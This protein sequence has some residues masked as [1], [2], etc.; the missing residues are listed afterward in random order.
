MKCSPV[1]LRLFSKHG[2]ERPCTLVLST[3]GP[4]SPSSAADLIVEGV[5]TS[6]ELDPQGSSGTEILFLNYNR[7]S[8]IDKEMSYLCVHCSVPTDSTQ[9]TSEKHLGAPPKKPNCFLYYTGIDFFVTISSIINN[10]TQY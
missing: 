8:F 10:Y 1:W 3:S 2:Y 9:N 6:P 7:H 4:G 5:C